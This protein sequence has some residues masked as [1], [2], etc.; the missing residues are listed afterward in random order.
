MF[1]VYGFTGSST[2][3]ELQAWSY[4]PVFIICIIAS[5][6]I[7]P[8]ISQKIRI[9]ASGVGEGR[10]I[11]TGIVNVKK[12]SSIGLCNFNIDESLVPKSKNAVIAVMAIAVDLALLAMLI[13]SVM[14]IVSGSFNPFI[15]FRF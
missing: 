3:W 13:L 5:L 8:W 7:V 12:L 15:Y 11:E 9:W 14:S 1:G 10:L 2:M 6:P 4:V